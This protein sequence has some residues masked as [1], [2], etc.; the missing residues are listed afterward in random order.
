MQNPE[1]EVDILI[2]KTKKKFA[3]LGLFFVIL[4]TVF[5]YDMLSCTAAALLGQVL[6]M[7]PKETLEKI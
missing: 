7:Q 6:M 5:G 3:T 4:P 1:E 2:T